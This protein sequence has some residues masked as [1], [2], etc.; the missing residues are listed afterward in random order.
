M[1]LFS[2][3]MVSTVSSLIISLGVGELISNRAG[4][5]RRVTRVRRKLEMNNEHQGLDSL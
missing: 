2:C 3:F 5:G 4:K 1:G